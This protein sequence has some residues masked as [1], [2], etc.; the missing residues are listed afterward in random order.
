MDQSS[1]LRNKVSPSEMGLKEALEAVQLPLALVS[2]ILL[3]A[4]VGLIIWLVVW[5]LKH[6]SAITRSLNISNLVHELQNKVGHLFH[7]VEVEAHSVG[8][9]V[10]TKVASAS[11]LVEHRFSV[12]FLDL[13]GNVLHTTQ[14]LSASAQRMS[15]SITRLSEQVNSLSTSVSTDQGQI[16]STVHQVPGGQIG[17]L[18]MRE[19]GASV[20]RH[21]GGGSL[22][23]ELGVLHM[24]TTVEK[25]PANH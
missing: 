13:Q 19:A 11:A 23:M 5:V 22:P 3:L 14:S 16:Q 17:S 8:E 6:R 1:Q 12:L 10:K 21:Q 24:T 2:L 9:L 4:F 25:T 20:P 18:Q 15:V 7:T